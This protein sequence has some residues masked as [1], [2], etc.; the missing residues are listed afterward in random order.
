[1]RTGEAACGAAKASGRAPASSSPPGVPRRRSSSA[2][3]RPLSPTIA[4]AGT[5]CSSSAWR[6]AAGTGPTAPRTASA[7]SPSGEL[8][9][10]SA[11]VCELAVAVCSVSASTLPSRASSVARARQRGEAAERL[12]GAHARERERARPRE[13]RAS[14]RF[15]DGLAAEV[16]RQSPEQPR[17]DADRDRD[18]AAAGGARNADQARAP[19]RS[20][21]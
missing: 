15:L 17:L 1:M 4:C 3:S 7:T 21:W 11:G 18:P 14:A 19:S 12:A 8:R 10:A 6:C 20:P 5:P 9:V 2:S 13:A 16:Q